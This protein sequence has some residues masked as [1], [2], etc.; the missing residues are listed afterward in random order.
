VA[1]G[2]TRTPLPEK[3]G[4]LEGKFG[5]EWLDRTPLER[6]FGEPEDIAKVVVFLCSDYAGWVTGETI[7][8]DGGQRIRG[9]HSYRGVLEEMNS[10]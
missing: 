4:L 3:H 8:A 6:R 10:E 7:A 9:L 1:P 2:A 5:E